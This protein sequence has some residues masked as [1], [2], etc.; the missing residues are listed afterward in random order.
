MVV[1][2]D[3]QGF[4]WVGTNKGIN[5]YD[6]FEL[7]KYDLP[8]ND[9]KGATSNRIRAL[10]VTP[11]GSLWAGAERAGLF[12][13]DVTKDR[14][15]SMRDCRVP[16]NYQKL[17]QLL[18]ESTIS[19]ITSDNQGQ[20]WVG[21]Q[22]YG[23]FV[24]RM[25]EQGNLSAMRQIHVKEPGEKTP[26]NHDHAISRI[27][28]DKQNNLWIGTYEKG[29]WLF[30]GNNLQQKNASL[31]ASRVASYSVSSVRA[32]LLDRRGDLWIGT[33]SQV[34]WVGSQA[35]TR[36]QDFRPQPLRRTF[37]D[38]ESLYLDS[39]HRLW[40]GTSFGLLLMKPGPVTALAPPVDEAQ[41]H[42]F[43][44]LDT[45]PYSINSVRV[46]QILEDRF[47]NLWFATSAGG[48]NQVKLNTKPFQQ[49][50]RQL[51]GQAT[52]ANN[53]INAM[54]KDRNSNRLWIGSRNGFASYDFTQ[55]K[56][57]NYLNRALS[58]NVNGV[59]VSTFFQASNG[60]LWVGTR[61]NGIYLLT[62]QNTL[63]PLPPLPT[64]DSW[65]Q[66][67][68]EDIVEDRFGNIWVATF[69]AGLLQFDRQG[70]F[71]KTHNRAN[72]GLPIDEATTLLYAGDENV[73]WVSTRGEGVIKLRLEAN[74]LSLLNQFRHE[75]NNPNSLRV[76]YAWPLLKD[77]RG[78]LWIGTIGGGLHRL[79]KNKEGKEVIERY[80]QWV[81]ETDI[82][83]LLS[84]EAGNI[85]IGG[86]GL[87]QFNP[88]TKRLLH[89][90]VTD[91]LQSNSFKIGSAFQSADGTLFFGGTNGITY[92]HPK[93]IRSNPFPPLMQITGLRI[94]NQP[95]GVGDTINGRVMLTKPFA[96]PQDIRIKASENDILIEFVGI[97]YNNP[98]KH[99][100]AY[101]LVGFNDEWVYPNPGQR[102]ASFTN[103]PAGNYTFLVKGSNGDGLWSSKP[104]SV[105][106][107]ILPPWWKTWWAYL[108]YALGIISAMVLYRRTALKQQELKNNLAFEKFQ[109]EKEKEV[110]DLKLRFF[111]NVS[112][113]LRTPLTLI[114]GPMEELVASA[115]QLGSLKNK[116]LLMHT[117][118]RKLL[119]LV[120]QLLDFRKVETGH[121]ALRVSQQDINL[122]LTEIFL[123]FKLK[124]EELQLDY[125]VEVPSEAV[126]LYFDRSKLEVILTNL[127]SNAFKYTPPGGKIRISAEAVGRPDQPATLT[128]GKLQD[129]YLEV[130]VR[131]WGMGMK[132]E[133]LA[134]IFDPYYQASHTETLRMMGTGIGLS[135]VK[136]L[137]ERHAGEI[138]VQSEVGFG[139]TFTIRLPFGREHISPMDL[140]ED[141]SPGEKEYKVPETDNF[142]EPVPEEELP[143]SLPGSTRIL[144]V[145]D[146]DEVRQYLLHQFEAEFEVHLAVDG[147]EGWEKALELCP[148]LVISDI[149]MPRSDGLE[150]CKRLKLHPKTLHIP[151]ILLT[152]RASAI[153]ELEGLETGADDYITKPFNPKILHAKTMAMLQNRFKLRTYYQRQILLKPTE[154]V[155]PDEDKQILEKAMKVVEN[156]LHEP[157]FSVQSLVQEMGM[158]QSAFYRRIKSITGQTVVEFIRDVR[159]KRAAQ[160]L[161]STTQRV[162]EIA[163]QVG[164]E[165]I[166]HFRQSFQKTFNQSPSEYARQ[167]RKTEKESPLEY[168]S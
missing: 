123:I 86:A 4:I 74:K 122:F 118:T 113:E 27:V 1:D 143:V 163:L 160:L 70:K 110:T 60:T 131:D 139:T 117:Q 10:H 167:H 109:N 35:L 157:A 54:Y 124:A 127:L 18:T 99:Q 94:M 161:S 65:Q 22:W 155:I 98:Q 11:A 134:N 73:L 76:N 31:H 105:D 20:V 67:S 87:Y 51:F 89:Y 44:P 166:K 129:N 59:D 16:S 138:L 21:T 103:L 147:Q 91:G 111:T 108:L 40:I 137:V 56:Y 13:Y 9:Q 88:D 81:P 90:D 23:I 95:V 84:D 6:G 133:D 107:T 68:I 100:Y 15:V 154:I 55:G 152:A 39:F 3:K 141:S 63:T 5:R 97:N 151:V 156:R 106:F 112:H 12:W 26:S 83:S 24:F 142:L 32:L 38:I 121:V 47:H 159:M 79:V 37:G 64:I 101:Q 41:T 149:M 62:G 33:N 7:K 8:I 104:A 52:P 145:E 128:N 66:A 36:S 132:A 14:F 50:R 82:E 61:H 119:D 135:L 120:N 19:A 2:Q 130:R 78:T 46:H 77:R 80:S 126:P 125:A 72:S 57:Q 29:L 69:N 165:D 58:G 53:Y 93:A 30:Q 48:L 75:P 34:F 158:S 164:V 148:D 140:Y 96:T 162:S 115:G 136:Q 71:L 146:N 168:E 116:V 85:W 92:F 28:L 153:H 17:V 25:D 42:T 43:L 102:T 45:D 150:L 144:V 49:L 114:L